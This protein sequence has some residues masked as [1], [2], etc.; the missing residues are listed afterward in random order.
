[1]R[2]C[3]LGQAS[4]YA[5][6]LI[7]P[8]RR[9]NMSE[10]NKLEWVTRSVRGGWM[11]DNPE[12]IKELKKHGGEID[13]VIKIKDM[14]HKPERIQPADLGQA[15]RDLDENLGKFFELTS[16]MSLQ[17]ATGGA[18]PGEPGVVRRQRREESHTALYSYMEDH[19]NRRR[20][21]MESAAERLS[22][23]MKPNQMIEIIGKEGN[24]QMMMA[25][26]QFV[27]Q[28]RRSKLNFRIADGPF[29]TTQKQ[30]QQEE[31][32]VVITTTSAIDPI[33]A[34]AL[35]PSYVAGSSLPEAEDRGALIEKLETP[36]IAQAI[37]NITAP[38]PPQ[39]PNNPGATP[40]MGNPGLQ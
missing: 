1:M 8:Q 6:G 40:P 32:T 12:D 28:F 27:Q 16:G 33:A 10:S 26:E 4:S 38:P 15:M 24:Q 5:Y 21:L 29:T 23:T 20:Y 39:N 2:R 19:D 13:P 25:S 7:G 36:Q 37:V 17:Q 22:R 18:Q 31:R 35:L 30:M 34:K 11:S 9:L 14:M 3:S